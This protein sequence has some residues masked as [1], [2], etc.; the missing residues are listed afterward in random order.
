MQNRFY[1]FF[2]EIYFRSFYCILSFIFCFVFC[3]YKKDFFFFI[4][5][6]PLVSH[7]FEFSLH[8]SYMNPSELFIGN[9]FI[10]FFV[11]FFFNFPFLLFH[12]Y[13]YFLVSFFKQELFFFFSIDFFEYFYN[14]IELCFV[15]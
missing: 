3:F 4:L 1:F 13:F 15:F 6:K 2:K 12:F 14:S 10:S 11:S 9:F 8:L 7:F 5:I